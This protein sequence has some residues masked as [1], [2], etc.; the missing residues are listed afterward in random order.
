MRLYA[1][2]SGYSYDQWKGPFYPDDI[3]SADMLGYYGARLPAVEINNTFYRIPKVPV[4][5]QWA[6]QG[7]PKVAPLWL[8][9]YLPNMPASHIAIFNDLLA[10]PQSRLKLG[11]PK[12]ND[13]KTSKK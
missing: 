12:Y 5:E 1:G 8:L 6:E 3:K 2:T 4:V 10:V 9:K 11:R 7:L 13:P